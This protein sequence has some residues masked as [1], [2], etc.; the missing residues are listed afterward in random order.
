MIRRS[1]ERVDAA[2]LLSRVADDIYWAARYLERA[3]DTARIVRAHAE[4]A[5]R[6]ARAGREAT[7]SRWSPI[8]GSDAQYD[9]RF[10]GDVVREAVVVEFLLSDQH[11]PGSVVSCVSA[12]RENLRTTRETIPRE[13]WQASTTS[14]STSTSRPTGASTGARASASSAM[15]SPTAGAST[16]SWRRR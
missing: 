12:A 5:R 8:V 6:P 14:T 11:N 15:S 2:V 10:G 4:T 16:A 9:A 3:E 13:G 1:P 7:G